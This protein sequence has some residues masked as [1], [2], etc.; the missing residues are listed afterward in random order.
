M[1]LSADRISR[2]PL[3]VPPGQHVYT[4]THRRGAVLESKGGRW[5]TRHLF[6]MAPGLFPVDSIDRW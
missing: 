1:S 4:Q 6:S 5:E 3:Q 2:I